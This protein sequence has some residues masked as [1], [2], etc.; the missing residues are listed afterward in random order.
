MTTSL[1]MS[2][3]IDISAARRRRERQ[4][5]VIG[6]HS[7]DKRREIRHESQ[8]TL[9]VQIIASPD[10]SLVGT[11]ISCQACDVSAHG[12]RVQTDVPIPED[13]HLDLWVDNSAGPGKYFLSSTVRWSQSVDGIHFAG[14]ELH[15]GAATDIDLWRAQYPRIS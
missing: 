14:V 6:M 13:C 9:F 10:A 11:T 15:D 8:E 5:E 7:H 3:I 2:K 12:L 1:L 4:Q